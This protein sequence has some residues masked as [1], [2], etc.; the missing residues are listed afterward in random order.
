MAASVVG[1]AQAGGGRWPSG[2]GVGRG[3]G[4]VFDPWGRRLQIWNQVASSVKV[5][6]VKNPM[7]EGMA[8]NVAAE[9]IA[10]AEGVAGHV[11]A[12]KNTPAKLVE[13]KILAVKDYSSDLL[14]LAVSP[15]LP[16]LVMVSDLAEGGFHGAR[17][18]G[19]G[20]WSTAT[21]PP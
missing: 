15:D 4:W 3:R 11:V 16:G 14:E 12:V 7:V 17:V 5:A 2:A 19:L 1:G 21:E 18:L 20:G 9:K 10:T 8:V 13:A 6:A